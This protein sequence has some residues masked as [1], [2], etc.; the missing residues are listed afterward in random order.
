M[1]EK[2]PCCS[3]LQYDECCGPYIDTEKNAPTPLAL[4]RSRYTAFTQ[5]NIDYIGSTMIGEALEEFEP[6]SFADWIKN[7][8]WIHLTIID[9]PDVSEDDEVGE[10]EFSAHYERSDG[11]AFDITERSL[12]VK[13]DDEWFYASGERP[14]RIPDVVEEQ[15]G[16]NDPCPCKSGKKY[17]K[18]CGAN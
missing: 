16:R 11:E 13:V 7:L 5:V 3:G 12:F 10:V 6:V 2:C 17:K 8:H 9:A 18:C 4:M 15:V 1:S 14:I